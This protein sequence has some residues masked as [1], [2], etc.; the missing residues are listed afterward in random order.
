MRNGRQSP[1]Q[2]VILTPP[3]AS[4]RVNHE[5]DIIISGKIRA[6]MIKSMDYGHQEIDFFQ[7]FKTF[8]L[9]Q[10]NLGLNFLRYLL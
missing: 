3:P 4:L 8:V 10:T 1:D 7:K 2:W 6:K 5:E 9:R